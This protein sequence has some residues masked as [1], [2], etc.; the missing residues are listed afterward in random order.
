MRSSRFEC[1][2]DNFRTQSIVDIVPW[3]SPSL[4]ISGRSR[5]CIRYERV[6]V[7]HKC[8]LSDSLYG[9]ILIQLLVKLPTAG[10]KNFIIFQNICIKYLK[11]TQHNQKLVKELSFTLRRMRLCRTQ[12]R[13]VP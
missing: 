9:S 8:F 3:I 11:I 7:R 5:T 2:H 4:K 12:L 10:I 6:I 1:V 13:K